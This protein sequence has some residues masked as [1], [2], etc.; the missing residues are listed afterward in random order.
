[1]RTDYFPIH[2]HSM[3]SWLDGMGR[4]EDMVDRVVDLDQPAL[5][6]TDHGVMSGCIRLYKECRK[7]GIEP[8]PGSEFYIVADVNDKTLRERRYHVGLLALDAKGYEAL[9][10]LSSYSHEQFHRKPLL[11][12]GDLASFGK[13][14][15]EHVALT[16]G[17]F[18]GLPIQRLVE[19]GHEAAHAIVEWYASKFPH[20]FVELQNHGVHDD[21]HDD[22]DIVES[23]LKI[24]HDLGLPVVAGQDSHYCEKPHQL[25][26]DL[27]KEIS[28]HGTDGDDFKFPGDGFHMAEAR[29][30]ADHYTERQWDLIDEGHGELLDLHGLRLPDL[31]T[32]KFSV[33]EISSSPDR[34]L[35]RQAQLG[36]ERKYLDIV[37]TYQKRLDHEL[38]VISEMGFAN[39]FHLV[40]EVADWC[41][42]NHVVVNTRGSANGSL[43]CWALGI[44]NVD[45]IEWD[46][47]FSRFLS[48]DRQ[49]PPDIDMDVE[50]GR[51]QDVIDH[52][53]TLFPTL[54]HI[55]T[56]GR[57]GIT[58]DPETGEEK[59]S[60]YQQYAS[61]MRRRDPDWDG[62]IEP[63]HKSGMKMLDDLP[64]FKGAGTHAG[65]L[66][67]PSK[68]LPIEKLLPTMR[69]GGKNGNVVTQPPME[70]VEDAGY[71][72]LD[73][74][75]L[76][77]LE[78]MSATL[79]LLGKDMNYLFDNRAGV[80]WDDKKTCR[81]L[82]SGRT[83]GIFQF[84]GPSTWRGAKKMGITSTKDAIL[85]LALFRPALLNGGQ[86]ERYLQ[87]R[88]TG[89][90][91]QV[92]AL[93][94]RILEDTLG[95]PVFQEQVIDMMRAVDM[96]YDELNEM[97]KAVKA[98]NEKIADYALAT[99]KKTGPRF[100]RLALQKGATKD[101]A[102]FMWAMI[103]EF[104]DYGFN[105]AHAT[106][107]GL[108][109]YYSAYLKT[110]YPHEFMAATLN[111]WSGTPKERAYVQE[112]RRLKLTVVKADVN[113]SEIGW[114]IDR[115]RTREQRLVRGLVS[116]KG[117]GLKAAEAIV[118][119]R[120]AN[121]EYIDLPD[122]IDR[123]PGRPVS[124]GKN[125]EKDGTLTGVFD[126]LHDAGALRSVGQ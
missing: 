110:H 93:V 78:T 14:Y 97:L 74:L 49:K 83:M 111:T 37:D 94:E 42:K 23:M 29:W 66:V 105:R 40:R 84:E 21:D 85:A 54:V 43:V 71:V 73:L 108:M 67:L 121:G 69:V 1:M 2:A 120:E 34:E 68:N 126:K 56:Y 10:A 57:L 17:C 92:P 86:T 95:V 90:P 5:A 115:S 72:K 112:A 46:T 87:A 8:F 96:P 117:V 16:T 41:R 124:G 79:T 6:L 50:S 99:I 45:P 15:G 18:F 58:L 104:G 30:V 61:A 27:M 100:R 91:V 9:V 52:L 12:F 39:Y 62:S 55:G 60:L 70:D 113:R 102:K 63:Q 33:P 103:R 4:V 7:A 44:T 20:T 53:L 47:D 64:V 98:S 80:K 122:M 77:A 109:S 101:E 88:E 125:W 123:L 107:Y 116:V 25:A 118:Q 3:Y 51:R 31:D 114:A 13:E 11:S 65:G 26:H 35:R 59:G 119:E 81:T 48:L 24:A 38:K 76:R 89:K 82:Q 106:G 28:Y 36:L 22:A 75:G 19:D 32:Y